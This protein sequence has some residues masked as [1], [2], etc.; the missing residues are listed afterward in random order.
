MV[1]LYA[2]A[3]TV[4]LGTAQDNGASG[5]RFFL[6]AIVVTGVALC[7]VVLLLL[8][9]IVVCA[10]HG[11]NRAVGR[12]AADGDVSARLA[13]H[14]KDELSSL[15]VSINL[16]LDSLELSREQKLQMEERH[17]AF[18]NH[19]P[20]IA[21]LTDE[22]GRYLYVNQPFSDTF[23]LR[24]EDLLGKTIADWMPEAAESNREHDR[25]VLACGGTMQFDDELRTA[26]GSVRHLLSFKFPLS[27]HGGRKLIGTVAVDITA[28]KEWE[29]QLQQAKEAAEGA[30]RAKSEFLAN[31]SHE[32]RT[33]M[34]G[35]IGMT[36]LVLDTDSECRAAR[37]PGRP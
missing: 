25:E 21:S 33:P 30:N 19:L 13:S 37:V 6:G 10:A 29:V 16:M 34:N 28:R 2:L 9:R 15:A 26:D 7:I 31:M 27:S 3:H 32:I 22:D 20:A 17:M 24:P 8:E 11:L 36:D 5:L 12:I 23:H 4:L 14:G 35:V 1:V 18:M